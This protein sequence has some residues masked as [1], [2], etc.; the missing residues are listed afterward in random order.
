MWNLGFGRVVDLFER[1]MEAAGKVWVFE[2][3]MRLVLMLVE[4][5]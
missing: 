3:A 2:R 4:V 1:E 5:R